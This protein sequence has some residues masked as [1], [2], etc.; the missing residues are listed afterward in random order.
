MCKA[1]DPSWVSNIQNLLPRCQCSNVPLLVL[2]LRSLISSIRLGKLPDAWKAS[3]VVPIPK[4]SKNHLPSNYCN[5]PISLLCILNKVLENHIFSLIVE[6]LEDNYPLFNC[7][8]GFWQG[9]ST[10]SALLSTTHEWLQQLEYRHDICAIF[11]DY[12]KA[13]NSVPHAPLINSFMLVCWN[14]WQTISL[15]ESNKLW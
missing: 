3:F 15:W 11:L 13:F 1:C 2:H 5:R 14:S 7:Q 4:S 6:H 12:K 10:V 9:R 8:W